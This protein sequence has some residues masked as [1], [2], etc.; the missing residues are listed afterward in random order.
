MVRPMFAAAIERQRIRV[1]EV[2]RLIELKAP[3][4]K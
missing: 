4:S 1:G 2:A 3:S